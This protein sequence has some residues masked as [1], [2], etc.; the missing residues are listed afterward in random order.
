MAM[1]RVIQS[2]EYNTSEELVAASNALVGSYVAGVVV[3][4]IVSMQVLYLPGTPA[5][6]IGGG[7][8]DSYKAIY[9]VRGHDPREGKSIYIT[10][11]NANDTIGYSELQEDGTYLDMP[12]PEHIKL[13][14]DTVSMTGHKPSGISGEPW[15][16]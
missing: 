1:T 9:V 10:W 14:M 8:N 3:D 13:R 4:E 16:S 6:Y 11:R 2:A 5:K 15:K 7:N 12:V